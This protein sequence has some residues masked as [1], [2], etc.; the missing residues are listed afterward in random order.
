MRHLLQR[1]RGDR[2]VHG[3]SDG[4]VEE[5]FPHSLDRARRPVGP[6]RRQDTTLA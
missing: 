5:V 1:A 3:L 4:R 2:T 6:G